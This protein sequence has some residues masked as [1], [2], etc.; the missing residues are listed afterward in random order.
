MG[1]DTPL[2]NPG[3]KEI[4]CKGCN[5]VMTVEPFWTGRRWLYHNCHTECLEK[6]YQVRV[7]SKKGFPERFLEFHEAQFTDPDALRVAHA[8]GLNSGFKTLAIIGDPAS[9]K[10]RLMWHVIGRFFTE[11]EQRTKQVRWV[12]YWLYS[13]LMSDPDRE[14]LK[15][16]K[17]CQFAFIDDIGATEGFGRARAN[18]Q[19]VIRTRVQ[20]NQ[21]TFL[22]IDDPRFDPGFKDLFRERAVEIYVE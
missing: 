15:K 6:T 20:K 10:S 12:D 8:F 3:P 9:G 17:S 21:W 22:T 13:D 5:E 16:V 4:R 1:L 11:M 19:D 7:V 14:E 18:L 2:D